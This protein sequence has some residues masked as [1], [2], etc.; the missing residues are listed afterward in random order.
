M[1]MFRQS[2]MQFQPNN[3]EL[4]MLLLEVH[5]QFLQ[6]FHDRMIDKLGGGE[7]E[8]DR[9]VCSDRV[10]HSSQSDPGTEDR[11]VFHRDQSGAAIG[12]RDFD[13]WRKQ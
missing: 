7:V 4:A 13:I 9:T 3:H 2:M 11:R 8:D 10:N 12:F 1:G 6:F 5:F